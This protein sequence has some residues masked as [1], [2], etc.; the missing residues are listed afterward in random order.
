M[1]KDFRIKQLRTT[2]VIAS[3]SSVGSVPSLL[4][5]SASAAT[6]IDGNYSADLLSGAGTDVWMFVSGTRN[7]TNQSNEQHSDKV[8]FSGDVVISGNSKNRFFFLDHVGNKFCGG[9]LSRSK[10]KA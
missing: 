7:D 2:Q 5:Y 10:A 1:S 9:F 3:G 6:D 4:V 8:L